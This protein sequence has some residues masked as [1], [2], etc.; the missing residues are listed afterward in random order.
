MIIDGR[1]L[2]EEIS[3]TLRARVSEL[4][5]QPKV[6]LISS[7]K[8][9]VT[10]QYIQKKIAFGE[11]ISVSVE[12]AQFDEGVTCEELASVV[13]AYADND[14]VQG[15]VVQLPVPRICAPESILTRIPA[16][17][18]IDALS[19]SSTVLPP[20]VGAIAHIAQKYGVVFKGVKVAIIGHGRLVGKP[21]EVW[22]QTQGAEVTLFNRG[23]LTIDSLREYDIIIT[24]AGSPGIVTPD[25][26]KEGVVIFDAGASESGGVIKGDCN[27]LCGEKARLFTPVPNG[28]GP[29]TIALLFS[30]LL[31]LIEKKL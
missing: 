1:A 18:D 13:D 22:V 26:V 24:G 2:A 21:A 15:I 16:H 17:K 4:S 25:M 30:N 27:P 20:V 7:D 28:V 12:L 3:Q 10:Q 14:S 5:F 19:G 11:R 29:L 9:Q 8:F 23:S 6:A 31:E